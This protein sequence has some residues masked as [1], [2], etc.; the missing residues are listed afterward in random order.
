M[1]VSSVYTIPILLVNLLVP[2]ASFQSI[3]L[4]YR[5]YERSACMIRATNME[6]TPGD[7]VGT[8]NSNVVAVVDAT[9]GER[10]FMY[11]TAEQDELLRR[12]G[13]S[14]A[15][16]MNTN[17]ALLKPTIVKRRSSSRTTTASTATTTTRGGFGTSS[18]KN[19]PPSDKN[20]EARTQMMIEGLAQ[21]VKRDGIVRIDNVL[22]NELA[23][24]LKTYLVDLRARGIRAVERGE[25]SS[26]ER[27]ADVLLN[28]NRCD[29]KIPLGPESVNQALHHLLCHSLVGPLL[30]HIFDSYGENQPGGQAELYELNCFMSNS[31][32]R[33]QLVHA[34]NVCVEPGVL[35]DD[36]PVMLTAFVALQDI[37]ERM[38]PTTWLL[39]TNNRAAHEQF[40]GD[41]KENILKSSKKVVGCL[42]KGAC[43]VFDPRTLHCGGA[44][45]SQDPASTRAL[46]Y[47]SFKNPSV[48]YP[49][50]PTCSGYGIADAGFT[51]KE[52][53]TELSKQIERKELS[54]R[55][56]FASSFP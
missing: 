22:S 43:A 33:R 35:P 42:P 19:I 8:N 28:Q 46:F 48:D 39:G 17:T 37:D 3:H 51:L 2:A 45:T 21:V 32:A 55:L 49:G 41:K 1:V 34:D 29:L 10:K 25:A 30:E 31:G 6:T 27:F 14:E 47:I 16:L 7:D 38:G 5:R 56:D 36:E 20:T 9:T 50:C 18:G 23:D 15:E 24:R 54:T 40:Y 13:E 44:N 12:K 11:M 53:R 4:T 52:L 26:Q